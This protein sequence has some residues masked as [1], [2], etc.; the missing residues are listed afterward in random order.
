MDCAKSKFL[1]ELVNK[2]LTVAATGTS[3]DDDFHA[4]A[5]NIQKRSGMFFVHTTKDHTIITNAQGVFLRKKKLKYIS[6]EEDYV[7]RGVVSQIDLADG[8]FHGMGR[9][10]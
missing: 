7:V 2:G 5:L 10:I 9:R 3:S 6:M 1:R 8:R 4:V